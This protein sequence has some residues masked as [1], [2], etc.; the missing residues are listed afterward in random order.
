MK[1]VTDKS[2]VLETCLVIST[3]LIV[4]FLI[5]GH[6]IFV[7]LSVVTGLIGIFI[8]PL[9]KLI[10]KGWF[11]LASILGTIT[12]TVILILVY[13]LILIP[14]AIIYKLSN[15]ST[16]DLKNPGTSMWHSRD[17]QYQ[18]EDLENVW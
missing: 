1:G 3:G 17:H 8:K 4:I 15:K 2:K 13:C 6:M 18:R 14:L 5:T 16:L 11:G 10:S 9:A 12:S 7:Y